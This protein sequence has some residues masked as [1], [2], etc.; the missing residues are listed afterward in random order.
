MKYVRMMV[1]ALAALLAS[2]TPP[3]NAPPGNPPPETPPVVPPPAGLSGPVKAALYDGTTVRLWDGVNAVDWK[4]GAA[5]KGNGR[6]IAVGRTLYFLDASGAVTSTMNLPANPAGVAVVGDPV[7]YTFET[8]DAQ[9]AL[10]HGA[11]YLPYTRVWQDGAEVGSW[12]LNQWTFMQSIDVE[13]GDVIVQDTTGHYWNISRP[14]LTSVST[15]YQNI[16]WVIPGGPWFYW[17]DPTVNSVIVYDAAHPSGH[18]V[19]WVGGNAPN[20]GVPWIPW[21]SPTGVIYFDGYG[22]SWD[23]TTLRL[24]QG[25]MAMWNAVPPLSWCQANGY[26]WP[27]TVDHP[28]MLVAY[29]DADN[30]YFVECNTG[31]LIQWTPQT[32]AVVNDGQLYLGDGKQDTGKAAL[33][34]L[35]PSLV[36][37]ALYYHQAGTL[38]RL[39][40]GSTLIS[41]FSADQQMWVMR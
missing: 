11:R 17:P 3:G 23:G 7:V 16:A 36:D 41:S 6:K 34:T 31:L 2:C 25:N 19:V 39:D 21:T 18:T 9:Y 29:T 1:L 5:V 14:E 35:D 12:N 37:G 38:W 40:T 33:A 30:L 28:T 13:N 22:N 15:G 20:W 27:Q 32:D 24:R 4:T 8:I 10:D 26:T